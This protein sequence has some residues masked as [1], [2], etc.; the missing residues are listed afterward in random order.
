MNGTIGCAHSSAFS[1]CVFGRIF[2]SVERR[3]GRLLARVVLR[4][5]IISNTIKLPFKCAI[6]MLMRGDRTWSPV[7][8]GGG[9]GHMHAT[10]FIFFCPEQLLL[11]K[12]NLSPGKWM[13]KNR[14]P[15]RE[16][17][18]EIF[19]RC[20]RASRWCVPFPSV[21]CRTQMVYCSVFI[22]YLFKCTH[23]FAA[24]FGCR[25]HVPFP[26]LFVLNYFSIEK[27]NK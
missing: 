22:I 12:I 4:H 1:A 19:P 5:F 9:R 13:R 20:P 2:F 8:H 11:A 15:N 24:L 25:I 16:Q 7:V 10:W 3:R 17:K 6:C 14:K 26:W 18:P 23:T 21:L 27:Q